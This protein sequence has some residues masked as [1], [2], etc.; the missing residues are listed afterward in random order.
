MIVELPLL[1]I[2]GV[3]LILWYLQVLQLM[4]LVLL[5]WLAVIAY[6]LLK[7]FMRHRAINGIKRYLV[8]AYGI[9]QRNIKDLGVI[10]FLLPTRWSFVVKTSEFYLI[11]NAYGSKVQADAIFPLLDYNNK[12]ISS[13]AKSSTASIFLDFARFP[14][15]IARP[16]K[17]GYQIIFTDLR[18]HF[19]GITPLTAKV[20]L[21]ASLQVLEESYGWGNREKLG[22]L[23]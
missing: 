7:V 10:P 11:G 20:Q 23:A 21:N 19:S 6:I 17:D 12:L 5:G 2:G 16:N 3:S 4:E 22:Q 14:S 1:V 8:K 18:Y 13:A 15:A 9:E